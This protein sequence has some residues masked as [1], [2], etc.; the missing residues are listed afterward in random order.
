MNDNQIKLDLI[1]TGSGVPLIYTHGWADDR[2]A[3]DGVI[4]S[5]GMRLV[6]LLGVFGGMVSQMLLLQEITQ[7]SYI[8]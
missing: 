4:D 7:N 3:W 6:I 1:E 5:L 8:K 2:T